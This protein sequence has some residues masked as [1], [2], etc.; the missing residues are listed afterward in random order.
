MLIH[1]TAL[2]FQVV[3]VVLLFSGAL[4]KLADLRGSTW[5]GRKFVALL[6]FSLFAFALG[7]A[8]SFLIVINAFD[9]V[10]T[11]GAGKLTYNILI[12]VGLCSLYSFFADVGM[13]PTRV[14]R[15]L[16]W[17]W[18][19]G[20]GVT[21]AL[22]VLMLVTP[23]EYR[24]HSLKS[25]HLD[26]PTVFS[27][28]AVGGVFFVYVFTRCGIHIRQKGSRARGALATA[29]NTLALGL[30][31]LVVTSVA[32]LVRVAAVVISGAPL[33][34]L[35]AAIFWVNNLG[36]IIV[37][38]GLSI[39]GFAQGVAA[40]RWRRRRRHQY[41]ALAPLWSAL[42]E[43]FPEISLSN[44]SLQPRCFRSYTPFR[45]RFQRRVIEIQDGLLRLSCRNPQLLGLDIQKGDPALI[46]DQIHRALVQPQSTSP[47][48]SRHSSGED[49]EGQTSSEEVI[50]ALASISQELSKVVR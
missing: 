44:V 13:P 38:V 17:I 35:N 47:H 19:L 41:R 8:L 1:F 31:V 15:S 45:H 30:A 28:Y 43:A 27:F 29:L 50:E 37:A 40:S 24:G 32:R 3:L 22:T 7:E 46:A 39:A 18:G 49:L 21:V 14:R 33:L 2:V 16:L 48:Q 5:T 12:V 6:A 10:T 4:I 42:I 23:A 9:A 36:Y 34:T 20:A 11:A 25:P 26:R